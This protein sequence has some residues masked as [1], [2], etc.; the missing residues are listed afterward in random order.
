MTKYFSFVTACNYLLAEEL[1]LCFVC[2]C[3]LLLFVCLFFRAANPVCK[4]TESEDTRLS[5]ILLLSILEGESK[6]RSP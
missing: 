4:K 5:Q 2:V 3:V 6:L 1:F